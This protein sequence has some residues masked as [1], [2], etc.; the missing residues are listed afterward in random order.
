L[1]AVEIVRK[2]P[3]QVGFA[4]NPRRC[5]VERFFAWSDA[6]DVERHHGLGH[7]LPDRLAMPVRFRLRTLSRITIRRTNEPA[8]MHGDGTSSIATLADLTVARPPICSGP[9]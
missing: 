1:I 6:S 7:R 3:D 9:P 5:V 8:G 4:V 2:N